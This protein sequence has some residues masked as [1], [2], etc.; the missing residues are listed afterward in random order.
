MSFFWNSFAS[1]QDD[2]PPPSR[3]V[4]Q[5][6]RPKQRP[7]LIQSKPF[8]EYTKSDNQ[9]QHLSDN[10]V[11]HLS[12]NQVQ[13]LSD[14][15]VQHL[16]DNQVQHLSDNQVQHLSDNQVQHLSDNR[17]QSNPFEPL[18]IYKNVKPSPLKLNQY[19]IHSE[20]TPVHSNYNSPRISVDRLPIFDGSNVLNGGIYNDE[21]IHGGHFTTP[22]CD[23][24]RV[25]LAELH[26]K[27]SEL[28]VDMTRVQEQF[29][30]ITNQLSDL[31]EDTQ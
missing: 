10:Q 4:A 15:Q 29:I 16:S 31:Y 30:A 3:Q 26:H 9:V 27:Y 19:N 23:D 14:N 13:H 18:Y 28:V 2:T 17:F 24:M 1:L 22:R 8:Q 11:Q 25:R 20:C 21:K 5:A 7:P 6:P 12:D